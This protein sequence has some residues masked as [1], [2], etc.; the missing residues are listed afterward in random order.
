MKLDGFHRE[1]FRTTNARLHLWVEIGGDVGDVDGR[2]MTN[3]VECTCR[4]WLVLEV[5]MHTKVLNN[6]FSSTR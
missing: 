4:W 3:G 1:L 2:L 6:V 5:T